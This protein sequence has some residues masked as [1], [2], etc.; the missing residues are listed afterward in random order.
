MPKAAYA[1]WISP[2]QTL[3]SAVFQ[4]EILSHYSRFSSVVNEGYGGKLVAKERPSP[5]QEGAYFAQVTASMTLIS[6]LLEVP[7]VYKDL[8]ESYLS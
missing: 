6:N 3:S 4:V 7:G 8:R 5:S 1:K 2:Y